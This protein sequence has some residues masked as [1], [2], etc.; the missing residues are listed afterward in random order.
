M[1]SSFLSN[2]EDFINNST[3]EVLENITG[4]KRIKEIG[5]QS[6]PKLQFLNQGVNSKELML[7]FLLKTMEE[8]ITDISEFTKDVADD[9][10]ELFKQ[11]SHSRIHFKRNSSEFR[12]KIDLESGDKRQLSVK[13]RGTYYTPNFMSTFMCMSSIQ[14]V[15]KQKLFKLKNYIEKIKEKKAEL[16]VE[17]LYDFIAIK[18]VD[19]SM[20]V[21]N[22]LCDAIPNLISHLKSCKDIIQAQ[23]WNLISVQEQEELQKFAPFCI[24]HE[25]EQE[26]T[27]FG[28]FIF[29]KC[30]Y[31]AEIDPKIHK[32]AQII[33]KLKLSSIL[34]IEFLHPSNLYCRNSIITPLRELFQSIFWKKGREFDVVIGNPPWEILKP[35]KREFFNNYY[36]DF[37]HLNRSQQDEIQTQ[38]LQNEELSKIFTEYTRKYTT[39]LED[40]SSIGYSYQSSTIDD[41]TYTGDPQLFKI[42]LEIAFNVVREGGIISLIVQHNFLG[43]K[44]CAALRSLYLQNGKLFR[45]WEFYNRNQNGLYF[46]NVDPNQRFIL[47]QFQKKKHQKTD[48]NYKKCNSDKDLN[49]TFLPYQKVH[50]DIYYKVSNEELQ[51]FGFENEEHRNV[52]EKILSTNHDFS[53]FNWRNEGLQINFSQ[54]IHVTRN[55]DKFSE[56]QTSF[57]VYGGRS[58]GPYYFQNIKVRYLEESA[59]KGFLIPEKSIICRNILPN[60]AKRI[61]FSVPPD[62]ALIDNSCTRV[63][64]ENDKENALHFLLAISNS[65]LA[66]YYLRTILTGMNLNYYLIRR[67]PIPSQASL[68]DNKYTE[69]L[70]NLV[71]LSKELPIIPLETKEWANR[72]AEI[73]A[74][75]ALLFKLSIK[76]INVILDSFNF[77]KL[78]KTKFCGS[79]PFQELTKELILDYFKSLSSRFT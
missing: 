49:F 28:D 40:I 34:R 9:L 23:L 46:Q 6:S 66:E 79:K 54:D 24:T 39:Q 60:S 70:S 48:I 27:R 77:I 17:D 30:L 50:P 45:M 38:L 65:L 26:N 20:G 2:F 43:S 75:I 18:I 37:M 19:L 55:R 35:N 36:K 59:F 58:F 22:F 56:K 11:Y 32:M 14:Q 69:L 51:L 31:G 63:F 68:N 47:F 78:Q 10:I 1:F 13:S 21:G 15:S 29:K 7:F 33:V 67:I 64:L 41:K 74:T 53:S 5:E 3:L 72:F 12:I 61:I 52:F 16:N 73:E 76:E 4:F 44:S 57:S 71:E 62:G 25:I 8:T 42:F